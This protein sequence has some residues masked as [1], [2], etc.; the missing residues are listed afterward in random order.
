MSMSEGL[1]SMAP[2]LN[3]LSDPHWDRGQP[4]T[5]G[6]SVALHLHIHGRQRLPD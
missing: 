3:I 5:A 4:G 1:T 6:P 2:D